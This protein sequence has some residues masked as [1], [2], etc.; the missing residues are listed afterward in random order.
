MLMKDQHWRRLQPGGHGHWWW[1]CSSCYMNTH[2]TW[3]RWRRKN[4]N[5]QCTIRW[6]CYPYCYSSNPVVL[7]IYVRF[8]YVHQQ[9][10]GAF[11]F[12]GNWSLLCALLIVLSPKMDKSGECDSD[13]SLSWEDFFGKYK[14]TICLF[15]VLAKENPVTFL[16]VKKIFVLVYIARKL[17]VLFFFCYSQKCSLIW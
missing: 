14:N 2:T 16:L 9:N 8:Y 12:W 15:S 10:N 1:L 6:W 3:S 17:Y 13:G 7:D 4:D 11:F 5:Q